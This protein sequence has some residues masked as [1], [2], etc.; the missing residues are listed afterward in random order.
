MFGLPP[1]HPLEG[2]NVIAT[3]VEYSR[4]TRPLHLFESWEE[5]VQQGPLHR[6][7]VGVLICTKGCITYEWGRGGNRGFTKPLLLEARFKESLDIGVPVELS[8]LPLGEHDTFG[9]VPLHGLCLP[10]GVE[11]WSRSSNPALVWKRLL[12]LTTR[13]DECVRTVMGPTRKI[14][15]LQ[16]I[17]QLVE[18]KW[19]HFNSFHHIKIY[20]FGCNV[21]PYGV[22]GNT[23]TVPRT[24]DTATH[25]LSNENARPCTWK[26]TK[27]AK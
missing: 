10:V 16:D 4:P 17:P 3:P 9:T 7:P 21:P 18:G 26:L 27:A 2:A 22:I 24:V 12:R 13:R 14:E 19:S 8:G 1:S 5:P 15:R 11:A 20:T 25:R 6:G 23:W